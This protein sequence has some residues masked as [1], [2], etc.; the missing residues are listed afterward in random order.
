MSMS[1]SDREMPPETGRRSSEERRG[2]ALRLLLVLVL[3]ALV[4][5]P[6]LLGRRREAPALPSAEDVPSA[7]ELY[8]AAL[9]EARTW[10]SDTHLTGINIGLRPAVRVV[11]FFDSVSDP[12][13]GLLVYAEQGVEGPRLT[14]KEVRS[15]TRMEADSAIERDQWPLDSPEIFDIVV[16]NGATE[17]LLQHPD[18][19]NWYL[20]F[21]GYGA[22]NPDD[23]LWRVAFGEP[24]ADTLDVYVD[25]VTGEVN[26]VE[27]RA[28]YAPTLVPVGDGDLRVPSAS[29]LYDQVLEVARSWRSDAYLA[30][31]YG[32]FRLAAD[33][34][35]WT[36]LVYA[37]SPFDPAYRIEIDLREEG[38]PVVTEHGCPEVGCYP[39]PAYDPKAQLDS[40]EAVEI[41][42]EAGGRRFLLER[43][44]ADYWL[45]VALAEA[46]DAPLV[47]YVTFNDET[48]PSPAGRFVQYVIDAYSGRI[49]R[50]E[51]VP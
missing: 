10:R 23:V 41:A 15:E 44:E 9:E 24:Y 31:P 11:F 51:R 14:S 5:L 46:Y 28:A 25:P 45:T 6:Q 35:P 17:F 37:Y 47:W 19:T 42:L 43:S 27:S 48:E 4:I 12:A 36:F 29:G 22:P 39:E 38:Q 33:P 8:P 32:E 13:G 26:L 3:A 18:S 2:A 21:P 49:I 1:G 50:T 16:K 30:R 7:A 40:I 20:Q 34:E